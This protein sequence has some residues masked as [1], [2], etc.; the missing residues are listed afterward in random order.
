MKSRSL[1]RLFLTAGTVAVVLAAPAAILGQTPRSSSITDLLTS[2]ADWVQGRRTGVELIAIDLDAARGSLSR[3]DPSDLPTTAAAGTPQ[4][5]EEQRRLVTAFALELAAVGSK[6][7]AAAAARLVEWACPYIRAHA[8]KNDF[9]R[10][11]Q[12]AALAVLEGGIDATGLHDHID[13]VRALF[14]DEPRLALA[15]GIAEEQVSAPSE[16]LTRSVSG[17]DLARARES[18]ARA[19]G[20][21]LRAADRAADRFREAARDEGLRAEANLRLGHVKLEMGRYDEALAAFTGVEQLTDDRAVVYLAHLF[22]GIALENRGRP[23]EARQSYRDALAQSPGAHSATLRLAA[24]EFRHGRTDQPETLLDP[25]LRND[26]P[27]R[28]PWWSYYAG[29]WRFWYPRIERVRQ[30]LKP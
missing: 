17:A 3:F 2:Y 20:E 8:P 21:R 23:D 7:H 14:P 24:L 12:L 27:R 5:R 4:A 25:L 11:W 9:D 15:R 1:R 30:L 16:V 6:R 26:D 28:D 13:H 29:D 10:A 22:R 19:A 18:A